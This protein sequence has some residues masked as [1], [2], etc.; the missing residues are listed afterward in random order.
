MPSIAKKPDALSGSRPILGDPKIAYKTINAR[1]QTVD[2]APSDRQA[3]KKRR[4]LI[5]ADGFY[6]S[7]RRQNSV[8]DNDAEIMVPVELESVTPYDSG[9]VA[10]MGRA[11]FIF[12]NYE[13]TVV[14][15][16]EKLRPGF[17]NEWRFEEPDD[18]GKTR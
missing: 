6:E 9:Y 11:I 10:A 3:L 14:H 2:T 4:C 13:W 15:T 12:A 1:V 18:G 17:L 5:P 7:P 16:M 8:L